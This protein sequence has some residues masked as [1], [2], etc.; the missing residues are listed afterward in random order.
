MRTAKGRNSPSQAE[1]KI[2]SKTA[3]KKKYWSSFSLIR[4][5]KSSL[6]HFTNDIPNG[7]D[8]NEGLNYIFILSQGKQN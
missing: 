3:Q 7:N 2:D 6:T 4:N 8:S 1:W 5:V